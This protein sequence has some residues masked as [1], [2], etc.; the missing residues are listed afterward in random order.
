MRCLSCHNLSLKT[1][2]RDCQVRLLNPTI[3]KRKLGSLDVYSFF[4][5]QHIEDLLLTK[6][7]AQGYIVYRALAQLSFRLF[8]QKFM[9]EDNRQLY[10]LGVDEVIKSGYSHVSLLTHEMRNPNTKI[11]YAKLIANNPVK[12]AGK[13]LAYRLSNPRQFHY[14]GPNNIEVIL[15]DDIITTGTTLQEAKQ[16]LREQG[17]EVL[18]ALTLADAKA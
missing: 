10:I 18:F 1:F 7:T 17:V 5:Y 16:L 4:K 3:T 13:T 11:L 12:Y 15:V 6:H 2:C 14:H 8:I 9:R